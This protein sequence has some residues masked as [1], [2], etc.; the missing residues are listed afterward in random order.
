MPRVRC[1]HC[2]RVL[3]SFSAGAAHVASKHPLGRGSETTTLSEHDFVQEP[4]S[5]VPEKSSESPAIPAKPRRP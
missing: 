5:L 4:A 1:G 2:W 3:G